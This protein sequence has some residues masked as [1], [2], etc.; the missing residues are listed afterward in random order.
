LRDDTAF[1][2]GL[3]GAGLEYVV[4]VSPNVGVFGPET[5]FRVPARKGTR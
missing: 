4:A 2:T 3:H 5:S 1:R